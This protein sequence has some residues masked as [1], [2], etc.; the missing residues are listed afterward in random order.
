MLGHQA[1]YAWGQLQD[2]FDFGEG[3]GGGSG[4]GCGGGGGGGG[5]IA[6]G[7][8]PSPG[9]AIVRAVDAPNAAP[10]STYSTTSSH[11]VTASS[12]APGVSEGLVVGGRRFVRWRHE[13][14]SRLYASS[15]AG[16]ADVGVYGAICGG[17]GG[18]GLAVRRLDLG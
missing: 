14:R 7:A 11:A 6:G 1:I 3:F 4:G 18:W 9:W 8:S 2:C 17:S 5:G 12:D 13:S 15:S 16:S 10:A